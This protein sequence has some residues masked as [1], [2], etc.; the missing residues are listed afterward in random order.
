MRTVSFNVYSDGRAPDGH[1]MMR[2]SYHS[3]RTTCKK[4]GLKTLRKY[5]CTYFQHHRTIL[6]AFRP[7]PDDSIFTE[8]DHIDGNPDNRKLENLRWVTKQMNMLN[9]KNTRGYVRVVRRNGLPQFRARIRVGR[10]DWLIGYY[11]TEEEAHAH[12]V[13]VR[14]LVIEYLEKYWRSYIA[15]R[16][17]GEAPQ[18][19]TLHVDP[20]E[21]DP[22]SLTYTGRKLY[23]YMP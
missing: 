13:S 7:N 23:P 10:S 20:S 12:Y 2:K 5:P 9:R 15:N 3:K 19:T 21:I 16:K 18:T 6:Q 8:C 17:P 11:H 4:T 22:Y 1:P 14:D